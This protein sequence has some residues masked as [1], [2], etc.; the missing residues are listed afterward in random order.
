MP[1]GTEGEKNEVME[2]AAIIYEYGVH[3]LPVETN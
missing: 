2:K 1:E 3:H